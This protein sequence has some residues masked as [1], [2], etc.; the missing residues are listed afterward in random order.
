MAS[1]FGMEGDLGQEGDLF[2]K[3]EGGL[4]E[5]V[6]SRDYTMIVADRL[7]GRA[8]RGSGLCLAPLPHFA[9]SGGVHAPSSERDF[10]DGLAEVIEL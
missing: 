4:I 7:I 9:V 1:F 5:L 2:L 3:G 10:F 6:R 8:F